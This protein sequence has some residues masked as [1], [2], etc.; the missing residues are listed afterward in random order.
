[1]S[2]VID[3]TKCWLT[4]QSDLHVKRYLSQTRTYFR[5]GAWIR[6]YFKEFFPGV[7]TDDQGELY[8]DLS[9]LDPECDF[10]SQAS[11]KSS[12]V[13]K[14]VVDRLA[15]AVSEY[16]SRVEK[17]PL[18]FNE[19]I[20]SEGF[21]LPDP[22]LYP[23]LY[24][25]TETDG[26]FRLVVL[27]GLESDKKNGNLTVNEV[28]E[29]LQDKFIGK[30]TLKV[31]V[32]KTK[33]VEEE[34]VPEPVAPP[35]IEEKPLPTVTI[36]PEKVEEPP[37][38]EPVPPPPVVEEKPVVEKAPPPQK[39]EKVTKEKKPATP[40][41]PV[42]WSR[43]KWVIKAGVIAVAVLAV[44]IVVTEASLAFLGPKL[45]TA[46]VA[47]LTGVDPVEVRQGEELVLPDGKIVATEKN[48]LKVL[49]SEFPK[50][51]NY[52]FITRP[53][54]S[55]DDVSGET[56]KILYSNARNDLV[57]APVA[58]L[59]VNQKCVHVGDEVTASVFQSFHENDHRSMDYSISWGESFD[60]VTDPETLLTHTYEEAGDF[61]V[62][63]WVKDNENHQDYDMVEIKVVDPEEELYNDFQYP[64]VPDAEILSVK[65]SDKSFDVALGIGGTHDPDS[66]V[67]TIAVDWGDGNTDNYVPG[68]MVA[69]HV[70]AGTT[71][72]AVIHVMA[73]DEDGIRSV[74]AAELA[75]DFQSTLLNDKTRFGKE[76]E[77]LTFHKSIIETESEDFSMQKSVSNEPVKNKKRLRFS[78]DNP[79]SDP[80]LPLIN[81]RWSISGPAGLEATLKDAREIEILGIDGAYVLTV[82]A[83]TPTGEKYQIEHRF[84]INIKN[85]LSFPVKVANWFAENLSAI[86]PSKMF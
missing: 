36:I 27:W 10:S 52:R 11:L 48:N 50:A 67:S 65:K 56:T 55:T 49:L 34:P 21:S 74:D 62:S 54:G 85:Q 58:S 1:M 76:V 75:L 19:E 45:V 40:R 4:D 72:M 41:E 83:E 14:E 35:V 31:G 8:F 15:A 29:I 47:S 42:D 84:T 24:I 51:G 46:E 81:V 59:R 9:S 25:V 32:A 86:S 82:N 68:T 71:K 39:K 79:V 33:K 64:P 53:M 22:K 63:L 6:E 18:N 3:D 38:P 2:I 28:V 30:P 80:T 5:E 23:D 77:A 66:A 43:Y 7:A 16:N 70:Y 78:L 61:M 60:P 26:D 44:L 57:D 73:T 12:K 37:A 13:P 20:S 17:G 69:Q